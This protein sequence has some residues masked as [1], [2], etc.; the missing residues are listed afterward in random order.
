LVDKHD[1]KNEQQSDE[2]TNSEA[3]H[4]SVVI[5]PEASLLKLDLAELWN[6]RD[7]VRSLVR[8]DFL[9]QYKQTVLGP[10]WH[11]FQ[12]VITTLIFTVIFGRVAKLPTD[13]LPAFLFYLSGNVIWIYFAGVLNETAATFKHNGQLMQK[14]YFPRLVFPITTAVS[15]LIGLGIQFLIFCGF[16]AYYYGTGSP[17][18]LNWAVL[19]TPFLVVLVALFSFSVGIIVAATTTK[20]RDMIIFIAFAVQ[21]LMFA[22]PV[23]YPI[24]MIP[25]AYQGL[26]SLN[27]V[28]VVIEAFRYGWMGEGLFSMRLLTQATLVTGITLIIGLAMFNKVQRTSQDTL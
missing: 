20:Y 6:Y 27:P 17:L 21:L 16:L 11:F 7:L 22:T 24:S 1:N 10:L 2:N 12:P 26:A 5:L 23:I 28:A 15:K 18:S 4:W 13:G 3:A 14:V 9:V 19:L 25:E 8:R